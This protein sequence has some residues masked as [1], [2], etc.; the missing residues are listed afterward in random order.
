MGKKRSSCPQPLYPHTNPD[1][2]AGT[3]AGVLLFSNIPPTQLETGTHRD[4]W[5]SVVFKTRD[6]WKTRLTLRNLSSPAIESPVHTSTPIDLG[7]ACPVRRPLWGP[8]RRRRRHPT[9]K[10]PG[11]SARV[12]YAI[13]AACDAMSPR[14]SHATTASLPAPRARSSRLVVA[15]ESPLRHQPCDSRDTSGWLTR[16]MDT[17]IRAARAAADNGRQPQPMCRPCH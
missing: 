3:P 9:V 4:Q 5:T 12:V 11:P 7:S 17:G 8:L 14:H 2:K 1:V 10:R 16:G 15:G 6:P 13:V